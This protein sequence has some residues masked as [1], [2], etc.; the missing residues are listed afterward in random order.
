MFKLNREN[1]IVPTS[2]LGQLVIRQDVRADLIA[3]TLGAIALSEVR[4]PD[5]PV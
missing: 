2:F 1:R 5:N 3:E 4:S